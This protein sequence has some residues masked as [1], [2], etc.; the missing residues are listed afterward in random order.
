MLYWLT[1]LGMAAISLTFFRYITSV[2]VGP[3]LTALIFGLSVWKTADRGARKRQG[4]GQADPVMTAKQE[5]ISVKAGTPTIVRIADCRRIADLRRCFWG[6][7]GQPVRLRWCCWSQIGTLP[8]ARSVFCGMIYA[9]VRRQTTAGVSSPRNAPVAGLLFHAAVAAY[10]AA[11][12]P[13]RRTA[14]SAGPSRIFKKH[15][16]TLV[17][18]SCP[19]LDHS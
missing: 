12:V 3:F 8:V 19:F 13:P 15:A 18:F 6:A 7:A 2:P 9:K 11:P 1:L 5:G 16:I 14:E 17:I 4:K 10:W